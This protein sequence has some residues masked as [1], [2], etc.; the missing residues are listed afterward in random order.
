MPDPQGLTEKTPIRLTISSW[1]HVFV[2]LVVI[3]G[4]YFGLRQ[5]VIN[6]VSQGAQNAKDIQAAQQSIIEMRLD[7][8]SIKDNV[9]YFRQQYEQDMKRYVRETPDK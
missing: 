9:V 4:I 8:Q 3:T 5:D 1:Y 2:I 6:A 7:V